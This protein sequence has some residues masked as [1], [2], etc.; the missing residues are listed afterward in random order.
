MKSFKTL[1]SIVIIIAL[2]LGFYGVSNADADVFK[3]YIVKA[4]ETLKNFAKQNLDDATLI[5]EV[6]KFNNINVIDFDV[7]KAKFSDIGLKDGDVILLPNADVLKSIKR[8]KTEV[9][10]SE[11]IKN[12]KKFKYSDFYVKIGELKNKLKDG[13]KITERVDKQAEKK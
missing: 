5:T 7:N 10:K 9:E 3:N 4:E 2:S 6:L 1:F 12:F 8:A 13:G 11:A